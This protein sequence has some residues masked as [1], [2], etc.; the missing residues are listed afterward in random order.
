[1][2]EAFIV[3]SPGMLVLYTASAE[4]I[5][6][7]TSKREAFP[8][9]T[10]LY[11]LLSMYGEN[12]VTTEGAEW[13]AHRKVTS[14]SF[15]EKNA[16]LVFH[17]TITQ[18]DGL[19]KQW[20][21]PEGKGNTTIKTVEDDT[22][23]LML[24]IIGYAG[25]GLKLLWSGQSLPAG[26]DPKLAKYS[27]LEPPPGY[28]LN[29]KDA[30]AGML[31]HII[32]LVILPRWLMRILPFNNIR[33]AL[34]SE[35]NLLKYFDQFVQDK[36]EDAKQGKPEQGMDIMGMLVRTSYGDQTTGLKKDTKLPRLQNSEI[37]GNAFVMMVAG[38]ETTANATHFTLLQLAA[39]PEAQR[40]VQQDVDKIFGGSDPKTWDYDQCVNPLMASYVGACMNETLRTMPPGVDI[41]KR[42]SPG[43]DQVLTLEGQ[44]HV[45]P[46][47]MH[48]GLVAVAAQHNPRYWPA[49]PSKITGAE[50][51][52]LDWVP[53]RWFRGQVSNSNTEVEGAD[54]EDFGGF[55]GPDTSTQLFRPVRGSY[56]P[57]SDGARSCLGRRIAQV[58]MVA[59]LSCIFQKYSIELAV[60]EWASDEEVEKMNKEQRRAVYEKA[61]AKARATMREATSLITLKLHGNKYVPIRLVARG[62]ERFVDC[63]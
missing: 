40:L 56:L 33:T 14:T 1:M 3:V 55:A 18:T 38:H 13:R 52:I 2:G 63:I 37:I 8:K 29:F 12:V 44:E 34:K 6:Q 9:P 54:S 23:T 46:A 48:V 4:A 26:T 32:S 19:L 24:H 21:G 17:E 42:V 60:D 49:K 35:N 41:P 22:M 30:L 57:F 36:I 5:H 47:G 20:L 61:Q 59:A 50:S 27:L 31:H 43:R 28:T 11:K 7:V 62:Q 10:D 15:N 45:L 51:D 16:A 39:N 53:E 25:F 58:E